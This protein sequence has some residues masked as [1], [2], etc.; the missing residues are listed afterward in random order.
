MLLPIVVI[1]AAFLL[2]ISG[3]IYTYIEVTKRYKRGYGDKPT[4][5]GVIERAWDYRIL[6]VIASAVT[7]GTVIIVGC[8][9]LIQPFA[10][11]DLR[12]ELIFNAQ[13]IEQRAAILDPTDTIAKSKLNQDITE[14]NEKLYTQKLD[15]R[16]IWY[17]AFIP[18]IGR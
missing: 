13:S 4:L 16:S 11:F 1:T 15:E 17:G 18:N 12:D 6:T 5:K 2:F 14:F 8:A 7:V 10:T 9:F 3:V